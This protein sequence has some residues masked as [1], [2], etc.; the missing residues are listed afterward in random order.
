MFLDFTH[1]LVSVLCVF[2]EFSDLCEDLVGGFQCLVYFEGEVLVC[3]RQF[4]DL[5]FETL[6]CHTHVIDLSLHILCFVHWLLDDFCERVAFLGTELINEI[7]AESM[8]IDMV[9]VDDGHL[10]IAIWVSA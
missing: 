4:T 7:G 2:L 8:C 3:T 5:S 6:Y 10:M 1:K 9:L